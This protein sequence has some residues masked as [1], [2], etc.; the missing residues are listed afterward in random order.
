[1]TATHLKR[2]FANQDVFTLDRSVAGMT[3]SEAD[4][5]EAKSTEGEGEGD[6][7]P[8]TA[9]ATPT[10]EEPPSLAQPCDEP[11]KS[12][13]DGQTPLAGICSPVKNPIPSHSPEREYDSDSTIGAHPKQD[14]HPPRQLLRPP[15][16]AV[17]SSGMDSDAHGFVS[18]L[19]RRSRPTPR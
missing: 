8:S 9:T 18:R 7:G 14:L 15:N 3:V 4:E 16:D 12:P 6:S 19:P 10:D 17:E 11:S 1:M 13:D 5:K 2:L